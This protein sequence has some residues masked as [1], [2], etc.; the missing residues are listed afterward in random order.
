MPPAADLQDF[1]CFSPLSPAGEP[2]AGENEDSQ[3]I[4]AAEPY[5]VGTHVPK[6]GAIT[7]RPAAAFCNRASLS[8]M[9]VRA[10]LRR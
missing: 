10:A 5:F 2:G 6:E 8:E 3:C 4:L 7:L 1:V 9:G